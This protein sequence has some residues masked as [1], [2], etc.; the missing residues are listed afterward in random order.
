[1]KNVISNASDVQIYGRFNSNSGFDYTYVGTGARLSDAVIS[2]VSVNNNYF[3]CGQSNG[4]SGILNASQG[5]LSIPR[6]AATETRFWTA[7]T[8]GSNDSLNS[9]RLAFFVNNLYADTTAISSITFF[10]SSST[11][12]SGT[13][14]IYGV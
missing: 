14:Y 7:Q 4:T 5:V 10:T 12:N 6:Y 9:N 13:V 11:F 2:A 8:F 1:L 3:F